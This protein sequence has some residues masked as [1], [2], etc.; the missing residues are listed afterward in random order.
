MGGLLLND[1][2]FRVCLVILNKFLIK[3]FLRFI[4]SGELLYF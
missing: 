1:I 4:N 3:K 2:S